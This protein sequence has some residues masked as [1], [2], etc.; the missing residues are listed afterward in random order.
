MEQRT[1][2]I[3]ITYYRKK[4]ELKQ[5]DICSGICSVAKLSRLEQGYREI[6]S[7]IGESLLGR[8]GKEITLF[9]LLLNE[10]DYD[11]WKKRDVIQKCVENGELQNAEKYIREYRK[12]MP[13]EDA[14]HEQFCMYEEALMMLQ[15]GAAADILCRALEDSIKLTIPGFKSENEKIRLYNQIE[16]EMILLLFRYDTSSNDIMEKELLKILTH[17]NKYFSQRKREEIGI[18]IFFE[19]I[20][21]ANYA[22][23]YEKV[24]DYAEKAINL[25]REGKRFRFLSQLFLIKAKAIRKCYFD[26]EEWQSYREVCIEA[27]KISY[28]LFEFEENKAGQDEAALFCEE[29]LGCHITEPEI[30]YD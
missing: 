21:H 14:V 4:Y 27:C 11:L 15:R 8:I 26:K 2:E 19:L 16:I 5:E 20:G 17:V 13:T 12:V 30:S 10:E 22:G 24:I 23:N 25:I 3:E 1:L 28:Y 18:Q 7:L 29:E 9:E 6:D